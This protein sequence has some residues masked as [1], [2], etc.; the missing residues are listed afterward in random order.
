LSNIPEWHEKCLNDISRKITD[1]SHFSPKHQEAGFPLATVTNM[2]ED[3]ID[4]ESCYKISREDY[5][6]LV[7]DG[8]KPEINDVLF[9]KDG[10]VGLSLVFNQNTDVVLL[11]SIAIIKPKLSNIYPYYLKYVLSSES[12]LNTVTRAKT[13]SALKRIILKD[14]KQIKI[15]TP[16]L[17]EQ[18]GIAEVLG[19]VDEAIRRTTAVIEKAEELK[20]GLM[21]RLLIRGIGHS[22]FKQTELGEIPTTWEI[23]HLKE[24]IIEPINNGISPLPPNA[25]TGLWNLSLSALSIKGFKENEIKP[26]P[27]KIDLNRYGL[28]EEDILVSRSNTRPLVGLAAMYRGKPKQC[29]YPDLMMRIRVDPSFINPY[30]LELWL[31]HPITRRFLMSEARGTSGSMVKINQNILE[32]VL[33]PMPSLEEQNRIVQIVYSAIEKIKIEEIKSKKIE[34]TKKGLTQVLLSGRIRVRLDEGGL[35]RIRDS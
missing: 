7:R 13:G 33:L 31:L 21:Q 12:I 26:A 15:S 34:E 3:K 5:D 17:I 6:K 8:D 32:S 11:S 20:R 30:F 24:C 27:E 35:H 1:G 29:I 28:K 4:I 19:T 23:K 9:S 10:T 2:R 18:R 25:P 14:I 22:E 16:P